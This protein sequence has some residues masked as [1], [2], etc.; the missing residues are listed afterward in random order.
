MQLDLESSASQSSSAGQR[1]EAAALRAEVER[2]QV[3]VAAQDARLQLL[4]ANAAVRIP[5]L[6]SV[7]PVDPAAQAGGKAWTTYS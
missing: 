6:K 4:Q 2:L 7:W 3:T 1:E 5:S